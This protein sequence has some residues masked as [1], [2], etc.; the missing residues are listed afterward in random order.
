MGHPV[1]LGQL[2]PPEG[3]DVVVRQVQLDQLMVLA[4]LQPG[5]LVPAEIQDLQVGVQGD[6]CHIH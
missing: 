5:D 6:L 2:D 4:D 3:A 1:Q